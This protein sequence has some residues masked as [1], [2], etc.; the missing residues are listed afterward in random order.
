MP[1]MPAL[2][3]MAE[4]AC[5]LLVGAEHRAAHQAVEIGTVGD[6]RVEAVEVW[7]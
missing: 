3:R 1:L 5:E 7:P 6:Q 4:S 2:S